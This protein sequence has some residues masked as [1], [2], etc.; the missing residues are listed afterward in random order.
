MEMLHFLDMG[1]RPQ[2]AKAI[3]SLHASYVHNFETPKMIPETL[4]VQQLCVIRT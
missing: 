2:W 1:S 3:M 4:H